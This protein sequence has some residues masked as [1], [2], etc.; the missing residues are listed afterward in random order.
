MS[1]ELTPEAEMLSEPWLK[2][3]MTLTGEARSLKLQEAAE[4]LR[5]KMEYLASKLR[6][7]VLSQP[8]AD[9][10]GYL[11]SN[12]LLASF[13]E[14]EP[15]YVSNTETDNQKNSLLIALEYVHA[16]LSCFEEPPE[17]FGKFREE[18]AIDLLAIAE[19]I[20]SDAMSYSFASSPPRHGAEFGDETGRIEYTAKT[21]WVILRG[22]RYQVLEDEFLRF[23]LEPHDD[24]LRH[25]YGIGRD[26]VAAGVQS[27][28]DAMREGSMRAR[29]EIYNQM[30]STHRIADECGISLEEAIERLRSDQP[31]AI[32]IVEGAYKDLFK[33]GLCNLS[34]HTKLPNALL[35]D[36]SFKLGEDKKF[37]APGPFCGTPLRTLPSRVKPLIRLEDGYYAT[38][39][40]FVRDSAYRVIQRGLLTR[41]PHYKEE[42]NRRQKSLTESALPK[43]L[44]HQLEGSSVLTDIYYRDPATGNWVE[45]DTLILLDDT[46][47]QVEAKAGL[48][49]MHSPATDF[50][51]HVRAIQDLVVKAYKQ[52]K[53][54]LEY[55][56]SEPE[57]PLYELQKGKYIEVRR[58][59]LSDYRL[60]VPIGLTVES[61]SP[62][63]TM[64]KELPE[65]IPILG[66]YPFVSMAID[67]LFVLNR[68]L[69]TTGHLLHYLEVRQQVAG[70][71]G[72]DLFDELDH[73]GAYISK[74]RFDMTLRK[75]LAKGT[76][77][78]WEGFSAEI[79]RYFKG[80]GWRQEIPPTQAY[81]LELQRLL[82]AL[83]QTRAPGW[84]RVESMIRD[85]DGE[86]RNKLA[87]ILRNL[88]TSLK[89]YPRRWFFLK[90]ECPLLIWL[91][92][93]GEP[94]DF[95]AVVHQAEVFA[96]TAKLNEV[97]A[98]C[99]LVAL[100]GDFTKAQG[101]T[102]QTP[103]PSRD[104]YQELIGEADIL[105][106]RMRDFASPNS[107]VAPVKVRK[108][109]GR[110][111]PCWCG[112]DKKFKKC[113]GSNLDRR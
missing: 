55:L 87:D 43:I 59:R 20:R 105:L 95:N 10:L 90:G 45:N 41:L 50:H 38:D 35:D 72:A 57:V 40:N 99:V 51:K 76:E 6:D 3:A 104:D 22:N 98:L 44:R 11:W 71:R 75:Q 58:I 113:H 61:F 69:P 78:V 79:D 39:P 23:V 15:D 66:K 96:L 85:L 81:P 109:P 16:V 36:L 47:L 77:V 89:D 48:G 17:G 29:E 80:D 101:V 46:L 25:A 21:T 83:D 37:F 30:K 100:N 5:L 94:P 73:L 93:E 7:L 65:I 4:V 63:S 88:A 31:Q 28:S 56:A 82:R 112:S 14:S 1:S 9:L 103:P 49:F 24:A 102:V 86:V 97:Q 84:L 18:A 52:T 42:W 53:R 110:N 13:A 34:R 64:C 62:F 107:S 67:D 32:T 111:E 19:Q 106:P 108:D 26:E 68:F 92:R 12:L 27:I 70:I 60:V 8:P 91:S 33:G 74:N 2:E 54:F